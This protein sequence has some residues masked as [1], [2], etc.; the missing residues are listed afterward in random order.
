MPLNKETKPNQLFLS[1]T[2]IYSYFV[3]S[4]THMDKYFYFVILD[5]HIYAHTNSY[6]HTHTH[7]DIHM[8]IYILYING[9]RD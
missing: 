1:H 7:T 5:I 4:Y 8:Y 9:D 3:I 2:M 6:S